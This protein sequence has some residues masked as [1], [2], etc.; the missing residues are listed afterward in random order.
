MFLLPLVAVGRSFV[1]FGALPTVA[2]GALPTVA[3][4]ALPAVAVGALLRRCWSLVLP[5][6]LASATCTLGA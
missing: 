5:Q 1:A 3:V 4:G 6:R 2:V